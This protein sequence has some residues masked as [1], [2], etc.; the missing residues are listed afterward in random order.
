VIVRYYLGVRVEAEV[1]I[2]QNW[3]PTQ[4]WVWAVW[5][6]GRR[7]KHWAGQLLATSWGE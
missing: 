4:G 1:P 7:F 3:F 5:P 6:D 2:G